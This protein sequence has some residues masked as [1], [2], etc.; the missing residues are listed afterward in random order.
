MTLQS[1]H[2]ANPDDS[3]VSLPSHKAPNP[4]YAT[5]LRGVLNQLAAHGITLTLSDAG[6]L[7]SGYDGTPDQAALLVANRGLINSHL[8]AMAPVEPVPE[9]IREPIPQP[10]PRPIGEDRPSNP[11]QARS[12]APKRRPA[13]I[14]ATPEEIAAQRLA[15][16]AAR[17]R[18]LRSALAA[19]EV[20]LLPPPREVPD[21]GP[22][23]VLGAATI[24]AH[25]VAAQARAYRDEVRQS[26]GRRTVPIHHGNG[27]L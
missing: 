1:K 8:A 17:R 16:K 9:P 10:I 2:L 19:S 14:P 4:D 5:E 24:P 12:A 7:V 26:G 20:P 22:G 13:R 15:Q 18:E 11:H 23:V 6:V 25:Q 3:G 21:S 27:P